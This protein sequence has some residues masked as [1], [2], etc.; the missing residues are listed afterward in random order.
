MRSAAVLPLLS[1]AV[2]ASPTGWNPGWDGNKQPG[3]GWGSWGWGW[4]KQPPYAPSTSVAYFLY[5][6]PAGASIVSIK[7]GQDGKLVDDPMKTS[8]SGMGS[9]QVNA[10]GAPAMADTLG[11]QGSVT[12]KENVS[13]NMV[14]QCDCKSD[15]RATDAIHSQCG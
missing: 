15:Q 9:L 4:G 6:E 8:T 1:S 2:L 10:S 14:Q 12:I 5:N 3:W 11:S 13:A 7:I